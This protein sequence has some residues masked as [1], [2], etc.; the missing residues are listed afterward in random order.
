MKV[1]L[2]NKEKLLVNKL[3]AKVT[4]KVDELVSKGGI[5]V[6]TCRIQKV[7][8]ELKHM[9][10]DRQNE[11]KISAC[12]KAFDLAHSDKEHSPEFKYDQVNFIRQ[13]TKQLKIMEDPETLDFIKH[14][15]LRE[16]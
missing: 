4:E 11:N 14:K 13:N 6:A 10:R 16:M 1:L 5:E 3:K 7:T 8:A 12:K 9:R 2:S 15:K